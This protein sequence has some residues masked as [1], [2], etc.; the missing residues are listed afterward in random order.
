MSLDFLR[1]RLYVIQLPTRISGYKQTCLLFTK[2][3]NIHTDRLTV[4][5]ADR[6]EAQTE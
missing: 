4:Q 2:A 1:N 3:K 6:K 5:N